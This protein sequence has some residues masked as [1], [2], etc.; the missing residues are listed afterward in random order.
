MN[1]LGC[2]PCLTGSLTNGIDNL[3]GDSGN[4]TFI[5]D[6]AFTSAAD[7]INGGAGTDTFKLFAGAN[8]TL[9]QLTNVENLLVVGGT[10]ATGNVAGV[11]GLTNVEF[12]AQGA[13]LALTLT[14]AQTAKFSNNN[15]TTVYNETLNYG[16][17]DAAASVVLNGVGKVG[18]AATVTV[19]GAALAT[20]NLSSTGAANNISLANAAGK[21]ATLNISGNQAITVADAL[22]GLKT[23][24]ASTATGNVTIDQSAIA[25]DNQLTFTG[26]A[27]NDKVIFKAGFLNA[28][29]PATADVL[30]GGAGIDTLSIADA[31]PVYAA[32]NAAKNFEVLGLTAAGATTVDAGQLTSLK[33][34][35]LDANAIQ[36]ISNMATGSTVAVTTAHAANINLSSATGVQDL[37][38]T[39]GV[40]G[41]AGVAAGDINVGQ[42]NI[43]LSSL[44]DGITGNSIV[45]LGNADNSVI[46]VTG[47]NNLTITDPLSGTAIG[48]KVDASA[49][50]G[51]LS[52]IGSAK[53]DILIGGSNDDTLGGGAGVNTLT[54]GA[55]KDTFVITGSVY[56]DLATAKNVTTITD[57]VK[58]TDK[59]AYNLAGSVTTLTKVAVTEATLDLA[60]ATIAAQATGVTVAAWGVFGG[61]TYVVAGDAVANLSDGDAVIKLAGTVDLGTTASDVFVA[62]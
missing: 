52:V 39:I 1:T 17:T 24:N 46:T 2:R 34:F 10:V 28:G 47:N 27:G 30:D 25:A 22:A 38:L 21:L 50:T 5:G 54:G 45:K 51:K 60:L 57:F 36:T 20:L 31:T 26:G 33:A 49:L 61:N 56:G 9:P 7:Q 8:L 14:G 11:A 3:T 43:A 12:D 13:D 6:A 35:S 19:E 4:N 37:G 55:G 44:G 59:L 62:A 41:K 48:S 29:V 16:A 42:T 23:I 18:T 40:A 32:I 58:G 53:N 15:G